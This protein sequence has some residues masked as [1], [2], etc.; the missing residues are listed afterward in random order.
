M[1][2]IQLYLQEAYEE[3]MHKV[4]W[5]TWAELQQSALVV[6]MATVIIAILVVSMDLVAKA[7]IQDGLYKMLHK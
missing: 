5:P 2:K 4:S 6:L 7:A 3:L 1:N